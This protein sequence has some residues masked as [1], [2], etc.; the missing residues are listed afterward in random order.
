LDSDYYLVYSDA[1]G[2]PECEYFYDYDYSSLENVISM[3]EG[4]A[5][6]Y[7]DV[8]SVDNV[9]SSTDERNIGMNA[10]NHHLFDD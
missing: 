3:E 6:C 9:G 4:D 5:E 10:W 8:S 2:S 7:S 1:S